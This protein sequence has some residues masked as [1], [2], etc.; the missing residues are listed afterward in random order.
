MQPTFPLLRLPE[1]AIVQVLQN[2]NPNQLLIISLV[3]TK[4][5]NLV[6]SLGLR[7]SDVYIYIS[8]EISLPVAVGGYI[9]A[10][11]FYDDSNIQNELLS[12]DTALPVDALLL[13]VNKTIQ[14]STP[15]NFSDW[16]DHIKS[17]FCYAKPPNIKFYRGCERFEIQS[18]KEAIGNVD[19]LH[20]SSEVTDVYTKEVLKHFN[21][22][23]EVSL[24]RNPFEKSCEIQTL[25][26]QNF[27]MIV[28]E[29]VY[30][31]DDMLLVNSEK[32]RLYRPTSQKQFNQFLK[33]WIRGSNLRL[34]YML[35]LIYNPNSVSREVLLKG[36]HFVD[37][38]EEEQLEICR[39]HNIVSDYMVQII[40]KDGTPAVIA[41]NKREAILDVRF[42]VLY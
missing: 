3:S 10:L 13:F 12:V 38:A 22:S 9:F 40:R 1:N 2:M 20:V 26:I 4:S 24:E 18:L 15:F 25:F 8:R 23:N 35:L 42:I 11:K 36:I 5:K 17:V 21:A 30:S 37:V 27:K 29:D 34:Q 32:V 41:I 33:H 19:F 31:L 16:L 7:A 6:T 14:S 28:F 39:K